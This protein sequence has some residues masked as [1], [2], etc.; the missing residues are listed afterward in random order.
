M[1]TSEC[2]IVVSLSFFFG[3]QSH[4]TGMLL[5]IVLYTLC[6]LWDKHCWQ[7]I[8]PI[9]INQSLLFQF[10]NLSGF[11]A[12][13]SW[14]MQVASSVYIAVFLHWK[15]KMVEICSA[16]TFYVKHLTLLG[17][18]SSMID[19][20]SIVPSPHLTFFIYDRN[21]CKHSYIHSD[22]R[23]GQPNP[24]LVN[25]SFFKKFKVNSKRH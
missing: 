3:C 21:F 9:K 20:C 4:S 1:N 11:I 15:C 22:T 17:K 7:V 2:R 16:D 13:L 23:K 8:G 5:F 24:S 6:S 12:T 19:F 14:H 10:L 18:R 25:V